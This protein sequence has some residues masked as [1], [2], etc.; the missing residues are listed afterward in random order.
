[1]TPQCTFCHG[2]AL[3][4]GDTI[5]FDPS[6]D[7]AIR[8]GLAGLAHDRGL[9]IHSDRS[10]RPATITVVADATAGRG[11]ESH[12]P[13]STPAVVSVR[14]AQRLLRE[15][16]LQGAGQQGSRHSTVL[17][18]QGAK[19]AATAVLGDLPPY[20]TGRP[21]RPLID[22][23]WGRDPLLWLSLTLMT[24]AAVAAP[25][26]L[27]RFVGPQW[28]QDPFVERLDL[29][30]WGVAA[31]LSMLAAGSVYLAL[32]PLYVMRRAMRRSKD[33]D[34]LTVPPQEL[35]PG[36]R[37]DPLGQSLN[38]WWNGLS[39]TG[40]L[41]PE[42]KRRG[43]RLTP[44]V[45]LCVALVVLVW[46]GT[47]GIARQELGAVNS[48]NLNPGSAGS[49]GTAGG[50]GDAGSTPDANNA[51]QVPGDTSPETAPPQPPSQAS[52]YA[53][54]ASTFPKVETALVE[55][56]SATGSDPLA[57]SPPAVAA[58]LRL[59]SSRDAFEAAL[60]NASSG[61]APDEQAVN[62]IPFSQALNVFVD[63]RL[64]YQQQIQACASNANT[65]CVDEVKQQWQGPIQQSIQP[66]AEAYRVILATV[67]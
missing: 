9:R 53:T 4:S 54:L 47:S 46:E 35:L 67:P 8:S 28:L 52:G 21:Y 62:Y 26:L 43:L 61:N 44:V 10:R 39:W 33:R 22:R 34:L 45:L 3:H 32:L 24:A 51:S 1:M 50:T 2:E 64:A 56:T 30:L 7:P 36:W 23:P 48:L 18:Q 55:Y 14:H 63:T 37:P 41:Q 59:A 5:A 66:L 20:S 40:A 13:L 11:Q 15:L 57:D 6:L 19:P 25:V 31:G 38:R 16:C 12:Q 29:P 58:L 65:D 49:T 42:A 27:L 17:Q 60:I